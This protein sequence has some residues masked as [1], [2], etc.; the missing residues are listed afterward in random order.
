MDQLTILARWGAF[1][2]LGALAVVVFFKALIGTIPLGGMLCG[3]RGDGTEYFS[4]GR[5]QLLVCTGIIA[6]NYVSQVIAN[7]SLATMPEVPTGMLQV[8]VGSQVFY[9]GGKARALWFE[10]SDRSSLKGRN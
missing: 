9:L 8:L 7:P 10:P 6:V 1:G 5:T 4:I 3:D 2:F